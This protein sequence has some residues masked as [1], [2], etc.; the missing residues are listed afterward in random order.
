MNYSWIEFLLSLIVLVSSFHIM[1]H[2]AKQGSKK[3]LIG[4][5]FYMMMLV[6]VLAIICFV[7]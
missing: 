7:V 2:I 1:I 5:F 4:Y 3:A 6:L